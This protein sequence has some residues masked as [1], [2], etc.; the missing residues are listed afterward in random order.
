MY[1]NVVVGTL[2]SVLIIEVSL[3]QSEWSH[4]ISDNLS[5]VTYICNFGDKLFRYTHVMYAHPSCYYYFSTCLFSTRLN[6]VS[7]LHVQWNLS[8]QDTI[9]TAQSVLIKGCPHF[10]GR[11][12]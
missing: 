9:G 8:N 7:I 11:Y 6:P 12:V 5:S 2:E 1:R 3:F 4:C 10:R